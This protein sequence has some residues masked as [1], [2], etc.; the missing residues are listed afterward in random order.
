VVGDKK[1]LNK[2]DNLLHIY[3]NGKVCTECASNYDV[4]YRNFLNS[5]LI[6]F[7][8]IIAIHSNEN[9]LQQIYAY[10]WKV[11]EN[12]F[13]KKRTEKVRRNAYSRKGKASQSEIYQ[14]EKNSDQLFL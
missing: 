11:Y 5:D 3:Q 7:L 6:F 4:F 13:K 12:D 9:L 14:Y 10:L 1:T 8:R 2:C